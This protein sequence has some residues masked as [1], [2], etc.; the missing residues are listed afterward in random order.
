M[1]VERRRWWPAVLV[2]TG[3]AAG[4]VIGLVRL[5]AG[6]DALPAIARQAMTVALPGWH[7]TEP[8]NEIVYGTRGFD[9]FGETFLLLAA[10]VSITVLSRSREKRRE[11]PGE[12]VAAQEEQAAADP[13]LTANA[14][15]QGARLAER[16]EEGLDSEE[17]ET[18]DDRPLGDRRLEQAQGMTVVVRVAARLAAVVLTVVAVYVCAW[19]YSPG[20]GFPAGAAL[21]GVVLV[22]YAGF[23]YRRLRR[24]LSPALLEPLEALGALAIVAVELFGLFLRGSMSANWL[25]LGPLETI[26]SGGILQAFSVSELFEVGTGILLAVVG[27]LSMRHDWTPDEGD[28]GEAA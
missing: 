24:A 3:V 13:V 15:E 27:L 5:P 6:A 8:V 9:T 2:L 20:G 19:G 7:T 10:V 26:R 4:L 25:P 1:L 11:Q 17:L 21:A 12:A 14:E 23:G 22:L 16:E 28:A 18:P